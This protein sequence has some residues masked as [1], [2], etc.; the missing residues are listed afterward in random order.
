MNHPILNKIVCGDNCDILGSLPRNCIDLV[1]TSPPYDNMK[2]YRSGQDWDFYGAAWQLS[3]VLKPG[4]VIVWVAGDQIIKGSESGTSFSQAL[5]FKQLGL[6]LHDTMLYEKSGGGNLEK[7]RYYQ[8]FEYAFVFSKGKPKTF[9]AIKDRPNKIVADR[10]DE[11][12]ARGEYGTRYNI[13]RYTNGG[14]RM[15][16][17][18]DHPAPF[19]EELARDHIKSWSKKR[20]IVLDP[21]SGS[22]TTCKMALLEGRRYIGIDADAGYCRA[23]RK[24]VAKAQK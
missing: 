13:W 7:V 22:G 21:F 24:R 18:G 14:G 20:D 9:N 6:N 8:G 2:Q 16:D 4:G 19:P 11:S 1:V 17:C 23:A 5:H 12:G 10:A 15:G 3:R